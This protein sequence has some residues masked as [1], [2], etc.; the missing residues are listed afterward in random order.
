[1][2]RPPVALDRVLDTP[3]LVRELV[4]TGGPYWPVYRYFADPVELGASG[5][6]VADPAGPLRVPPWFRAD[7]ANDHPLVPGVEPILHNPRFARAAC[8]LYG[9]SGRAVIRPQLVY[10]NVMLPMAGA[11]PG[12]TDVPAFR[13][14]DRE[15]FPV[16][17]LAVMGHS[18]LFERWRVRIATAVSWWSHGAGGQFS[19]W[20]HGPQAAPI[21]H[22]V[23][24]NTALVGENEV[25]FHRVERV[26]KAGSELALDDLGTDA[27][28]VAGAGGSWEIRQRGRTLARVPFEAARISVSWKALVFADA[29]EARIAD[30][31]LDELG[32]EQVWQIFARDLERRG[33]ALDPG[34]EPLANRAFIAA[35]GSTYTRAPAVL[36]ALA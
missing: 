26:G 31:Q 32:I 28:L 23:Y 21:A 7:W 35:L 10:V 14:I 5:A 12:H 6:K 13:G 2:P 20:P 17:L 18:G 27:E 16:W 8:Q 25:M 30:A 9:L 1:M 34:P 19:Y 29:G 24:P 22:E 33:A 3:G 4:A 11:D 15:R 36:P